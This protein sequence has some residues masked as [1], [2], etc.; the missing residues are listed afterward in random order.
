MAI[1]I[2]G[3]AGYIGSHTCVRLLEAG[4]TIVAY[5]NLCNADASSLDRVKQITGKDFPF[6]PADVRDADA[7][8][9]AFAAHKIDAVVHF[10][11]LKAVGESVREPLLYYDNNVNGTVTLCR[12]MARAGCRRMVFSSSAT[13]Y[14]DVSVPGHAVA[15]RED[16]PTGAVTN[17][18]GRTKYIIEEI[19]KDICAADPA[20]CAVLLRY[21]NPAG[22]H[23]SGLLGESPRGEP[24]N[25]MPR[26]V[27][28][29][30]GEWARLTVFGDDYD[31]P[32]G[33][34]VRDYIHVDDLAKGHV[35]ALG[36]ALADA[37]DTGAGERAQT[38]G[39]GTSAGAAFIDRI[40]AGAAAPT[41]AQAD[42]RTP[43]Y[44][45]VSIF[46]LG[47]GRG[48]SVLELIHTFERETGVPVPYEMLPRRPGDAGAVVAD[49]SKARAVL[50]FNAEKTLADM[51][52]DS[53]NFAQK[54]A[55]M[56]RDSG[57]FVQMDKKAGAGMGEPM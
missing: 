26:L 11:G 50:G 37:G 9:A 27:K 49:V 31:T 28:A 15:C 57:N 16:M 13:V 32:D 42:A 17:P 7:L 54:N 56:C 52:R 43:V 25:L 2:T 20:F 3:A 1:L 12:A 10:A 53:W 5:D 36:Y 46:N 48:A 23:Q 34:G 14:G 47:T 30:A 19:L 21:F 22:A 38:A 33:T 29:A 41:D 4:Y 55:D 44:P 18:Y 39:T 35:L 45:G 6:Y 40:S 24:N 51:C 8:G